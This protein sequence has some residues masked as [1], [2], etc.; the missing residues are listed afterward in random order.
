MLAKFGYK[1]G[2]SIGRSTKG[3]VEPIVLN[4][5]TDRGGLG[6]EAALKELQEQQELLRQKRSKAR[7]ANRSQITTDEFR[8]RMAQ[9]TSEK[10]MEADLG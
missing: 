7:E 3:I 6:K 1:H 8:L 9:K 10:Q 4:V 5:K 2:D